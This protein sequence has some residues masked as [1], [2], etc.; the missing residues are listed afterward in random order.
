MA[1]P[2]TLEASIGILEGWQGPLVS[3]LVSYWKQVHASHVPGICPRKSYFILQP[4][5][6]GVFV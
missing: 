5:S 6:G 1:F 3:P 2:K 4:I